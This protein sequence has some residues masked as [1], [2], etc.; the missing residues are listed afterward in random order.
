M[1]DAA[2]EATLGHVKQI[3]AE[4]PR[5]PDVTSPSPLERVRAVPIASPA[6]ALGLVFVGVWLAWAWFD[7]ALAREDW[8]V[9]AALLPLTL[10]LA[11]ATHGV[12]G[13]LGGGFATRLLVGSSIG[14]VAWSFF[15]MIWADLPGD[16]LIGSD[17][18]LIYVIG[19][20]AFVL[21]PRR[22]GPESSFWPHTGSAWRSPVR[23]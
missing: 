17:R 20:L 21:F 16:A 19:L 5:T 14:L 4:P 3:V 11:I 6:G 10:L 12:P 15:S 13:L 1:A 18:L 8:T 2:G 7:G 9:L 23:W 22:P